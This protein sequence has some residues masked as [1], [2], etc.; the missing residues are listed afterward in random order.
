MDWGTE[1]E[2]NL[3]QRRDAIASIPG[4]LEESTS[5]RPVVAALE[6]LARVVRIRT[7]KQ[8]AA[9]GL[10]TMQA[11]ILRFVADTPAPGA[12]AGGIARHFGV[13]PATVSEAVRRLEMRKLLDRHLDPSDRR[14]L[15]I[16]LT[17]MGRAQATELDRWMDPVRRLL[18][19]RPPEELR[20]IE[21]FLTELVRELDG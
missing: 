18:A 8:G 4:A 9:L 15:L 17:P 6:R 1:V 16:G 7:S 3:I 20:A 21:L 14:L 5:R 11:K 2:F 13:A 10:S 12:T 19:D